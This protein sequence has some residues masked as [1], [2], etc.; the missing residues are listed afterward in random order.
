MLFDTHSHLNFRAF[1]SDRDEVAQKCLDNNVWLIN[2]GSNY[3]TSK[4][5][6]EMAGK[7][8]N[9]VWAAVGLHPINIMKNEKRKMENDNVK[10]K[11]DE[12]DLEEIFNYERYKNLA[13]SGKVVAIGEIGLDA[14]GNAE[15]QKQKEVFLAQMRLAKELGLPVILHCRKA[16]EELSDILAK[17][18]KQ[19]SHETMRGVV[20]CFTGS[21]KQAQQ[22]LEM[23]L[24]LGF[25]G[26]IFKLDLD[27][28]IAKTPLERILVETDCPFLTPPALRQAQGKGDERNEPMNVKYVIQ[29]IAEIKKTTFEQVAQITTQNAK[30]LFPNLLIS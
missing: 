1:D 21:W 28:V 23:G 27:E 17:T 24:Y 15:G 13:K 25:N 3:A 19:W 29:K 26:I 6:V 30:I 11:K 5:A 16:H 22:Y 20:H 9:G 10:C 18:M 4:M 14:N 8:Q 12:D 2:V 7:Y